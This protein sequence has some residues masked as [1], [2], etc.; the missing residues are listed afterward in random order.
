MSDDNLQLCPK[1]KIGKIRPTGKVGTNGEIEKSFSET[2]DARRYQ[3]DN[4]GHLQ[5]N[6]NMIENVKI[7]DTLNLP[8]DKADKNESSL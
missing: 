7:G 6:A 3:C 1:C 2:S 5:F 4:C 8:V